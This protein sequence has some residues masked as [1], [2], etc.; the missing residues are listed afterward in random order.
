VTRRGVPS[1]VFPPAVLATA[2]L[3]PLSVAGCSDTPDVNIVFEQLSEARRVAGDL[4]LEF[5]RGSDA[6]NRA[7]MALADDRAVAAAHDARE[8]FAAVEK[9]SELLKP[10]LERLG[11]ADETRILQQFTSRFADYRTLE[12]NILSLAV[13]NTNTKAQR[14]SFGPAQDAAYTFQKDLDGL[15]ASQPS[16]VW[17]LRSLCLSAELAVR[18]IQALQ[19]PHIAEASNAVMTVLE[20]R[21]ATSEAAAR[22]AL[23]DIRG[24]VT[25]ESRSRVDAA[26]D[27]LD[28]FMNVHTEILTL[29]RRNTNVRSLALSLEQGRAL[30]APCEE[31]LRALRDALASRRHVGRRWP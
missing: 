11:Y 19:A 7:V 2:V 6:A 18:D 16:E 20:K 15:R 29:S 30:I 23:R 13:E 9:N 27:A 21:M 22:A 3:L 28:G 1:T 10:I 12:E 31:S 25:P 26:S 24:L 5:S 8:A 17:R 4:A 14:L